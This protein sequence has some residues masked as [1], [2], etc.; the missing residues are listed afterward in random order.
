MMKMN[1]LATFVRALSVVAAGLTV[2]ACAMPAEDAHEEVV[3]ETSQAICAER[4]L[5]TSAVLVERTEEACGLGTVAYWGINCE[6]RAELTH[7]PYLRQ[8]VIKVE[9]GELVWYCS[10]YRERTGCPSYT[11]TIRVTRPG[12]AKIV[13]ECFYDPYQP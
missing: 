6:G 13:V 10:S 3:G 2:A 4:T 9:N 12:G 7:I 8:R 1:P 5:P 11:N